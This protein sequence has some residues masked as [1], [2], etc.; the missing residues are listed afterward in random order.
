MCPVCVR[1]HIIVITIRYLSCK[2]A[3]FRIRGIGGPTPETI[4]WIPKATRINETGKNYL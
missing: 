1:P 4:F 3:F 2:F